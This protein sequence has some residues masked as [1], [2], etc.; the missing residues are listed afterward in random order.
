M[1]ILPVSVQDE[2]RWYPDCLYRLA[3]AIQSLPMA[4]RTAIP[5]A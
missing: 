4:S 2:E 5:I 1:G 3:V